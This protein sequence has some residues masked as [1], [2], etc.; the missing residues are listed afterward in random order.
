M[1]SFITYWYYHIVCSDMLSAL[2]QSAF[3]QLF[4]YT[5]CYQFQLLKTYTQFIISIVILNTKSIPV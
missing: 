4:F 3:A 1:N 2:S 5:H